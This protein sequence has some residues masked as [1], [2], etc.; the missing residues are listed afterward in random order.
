MSVTLASSAAIMAIVTPTV[1]CLWPWAS[2]PTS[3]SS[4]LSI[5][6]ENNSCAHLPRVRRGVQETVGRVRRGGDRAACVVDLLAEKSGQPSAVSFW[7]MLS[8]MRERVPALLRPAHRHDASGD[9]V[10]V[11]KQITHEL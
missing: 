1:R 4:S 3:T 2:R 9:H 10:R 5:K 11:G 7:K 8:G 6:Q